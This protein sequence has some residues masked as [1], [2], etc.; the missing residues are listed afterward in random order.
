MT[1]EQMAEEWAD[2]FHSRT[3]QDGGET[4]HSWEWSAVKNAFLAGY[5]AARPK[6]ISVKERLP[7]PEV[8]EGEK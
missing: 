5:E 2:S 7:E 3:Y 6:W 8:K 1:P 4:Y